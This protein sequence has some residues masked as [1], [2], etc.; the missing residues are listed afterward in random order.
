MAASLCSNSCD[1]HSA[2]TRDNLVCASSSSSSLS[3]C[4]ASTTLTLVLN[5]TVLSPSSDTCPSSEKRV[6]QFSH[7]PTRLWGEK[8][9]YLWHVY[10]TSKKAHC[11]RSQKRGSAILFF[12]RRTD[13]GLWSWADIELLKSRPEWR[14]L[15]S[16]WSKC[17]WTGE[18]LMVMM[19]VVM[20]EMLRQSPFNF[21]NIEKL[22]MKTQKNVAN[23]I[24][25][26]LKWT[27]FKAAPLVWKAHVSLRTCYVTH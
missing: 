18:G 17:Y 11:L 23:I 3:R 27:F 21:L 12:N 4:S 22:M 9:V 1:R 26:L 20:I 15:N 8:T 16:M 14:T 5:E 10:S 7:D 13:F 24:F 6:A 19:M 25:S 2:S